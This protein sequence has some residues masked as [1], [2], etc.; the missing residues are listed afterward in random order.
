MLDGVAAFVGGNGGGSH[1]GAVVDVVGEVEGAVGG[2]VVVSEGAVDFAD[3]DVVDVVVVE[4]LLRDFATR[5]AV[6]HGDFGVF[7]EFGFYAFAGGVGG[8][9]EDAEEDVECCY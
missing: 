9:H 2:V 4:H 7:L 6:V 8:D 5:E 3:G 1:G